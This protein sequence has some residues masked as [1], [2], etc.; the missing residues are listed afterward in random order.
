M[1][2]SNFLQP[3]FI[4]SAARVRRSRPSPLRAWPRRRSL[5][6]RLPRRRLH[7]RS[8]LRPRRSRR[9]HRQ[10]QWRTDCGSKPTRP[11]KAATR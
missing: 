6:S 10:S 5:P 4:T 8:R 11:G 1:R 2:S 9:Q 7:W 3:A